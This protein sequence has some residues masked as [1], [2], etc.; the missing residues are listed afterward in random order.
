[1]KENI[2][3]INQNKEKY[4]IRDEIRNFFEKYEEHYYS[5]IKVKSKNGEITIG[6]L[7]GMRYALYIE[8]FSGGNKT[9][10]FKNISS[11]KI[12]HN[13]ELFQIIRALTKKNEALSRKRLKEITKNMKQL[14]KTAKTK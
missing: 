11:I 5:I 7:T 2:L 4:D 14:I 3:I 1:M 9:I 10:E 12:L 8:D 6:I 13:R